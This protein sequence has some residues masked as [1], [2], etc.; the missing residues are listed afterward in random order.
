M[1]KK[2]KEGVVKQPYVPDPSVDLS[3]FPIQYPESTEEELAK[4]DEGKLLL[5][6]GDTRVFI[7]EDEEMADTFFQ[8]MNEVVG[9]KAIKLDK[10]KIQT[11]RL[12]DEVKELD[13]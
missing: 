13:Y 12:R 8:F 9:F 3:M 10:L 4:I 1:G 6:T 2:K 5:C 7:F 11:D